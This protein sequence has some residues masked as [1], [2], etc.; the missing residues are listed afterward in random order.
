MRCGESGSLKSYLFKLGRPDL[1]GKQSASLED[2]LS[3]L[4]EEKEDEQ[5]IAPP[6]KVSLPEGFK[7]MYFDDYLD[8]RQWESSDY[9]KYQVGASTERRLKNHIIFP[10]YQNGKLVSWLARSRMSKEWHKQ[11]LKSFKESRSSLVL[12]Y[13]NSEGSEFSEMVG[14][15]DN[16]R[17]GVDDT[18]I[19]VEGLFD[20]QNI[21]KILKSIK[22]LETVKCCFTFGKSLSEHQIHLLLK[23]GVKNFVIMYDPDALDDIEKF[24]LRYAT[25]IKSIE[26]IALKDGDP[27]DIED[28]KEFL[29]YWKQ[30]K[31]ALEFYQTNLKTIV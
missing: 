28:E 20:E 16:V 14:N 1:V 22:E 23:K 26:G 9:N 13:Y 3:L 2:E 15:I 8:D 19:L 5:P 11:N 21:S 4:E 7:R 24:L 10:I 31:S 12:R 18:V 17:E 30:R 29:K 27:N 6:K 25:K